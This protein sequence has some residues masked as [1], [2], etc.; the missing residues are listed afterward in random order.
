MVALTITEKRLPVAERLIELAQDGHGPFRAS[1]ICHGRWRIPGGRREWVDG[2][3][4]GVLLSPLREQG[5]A[6]YVKS[7]EPITTAGR[8]RTGVYGFSWTIA[9]AGVEAL[10]HAIA[11]F[12]ARSAEADVLIE[13][14]N[15]VE[16]SAS[17]LSGRAKRMALSQGAALRRH[18]ASILRI[19][20]SA[21]EA[22]A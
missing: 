20:S 17:K 5:M 1:E 13:A 2:T 9:P 21:G 4:G 10:R 3:L 8:K 6:S 12:R 19:S 22:T 15:A 16:V 18:A 11:D 14:A 7:D